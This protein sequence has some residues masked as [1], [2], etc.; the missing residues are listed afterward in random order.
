MLFFN[1]GAHSVPYGGARSLENGANVFV[2]VIGRAGLA[3]I[4]VGVL[5]LGGAAPLQAQVGL[6]SGA[7]RITLIARVSPGA[8]IIGLIPASETARR[9]GS[10][11]E[12]MGIRLSANTSYRLMVVGTAAANSQA[13]PAMRLWVQAENGT[14]V[15][16]RSGAAVTVARGQH[17]VA[18]DAKVVFRREAE[19][20]EA[21][22][23]LP[24]R[25]EVKLDPTI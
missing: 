1:I 14:F 4:A 16:V 6:A 24:V 7:V 9:S 25:Y 20:T 22:Q 15:E 19:L 23:V 10:K 13:E 17:A 5:A 21:P 8:S 3:I 2:A 11:D 12:T 18:E